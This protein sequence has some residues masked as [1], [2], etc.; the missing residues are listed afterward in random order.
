MASRVAFL[1]PG[2]GSQYVGMGL[3]ASQGHP[4]A[5]ET[6]E[7]AN[8]VLG[9]DL[10]SLCFA[11]PSEVLTDTVNA[12]PAIMATSVAYLRLFQD[13]EGTRS[14]LFVA[15]HS[16][17]EYTALVAAG[18]LSFGDG[19]KLARERGRLMKEAGEQ[20]PGRMAAII[21]MDVEP[22][23]EICRQASGP[24]EMESVQVANYNAPGQIVI[25]G[26]SKAVERAMALAQERGAHRVIPLAVSIASHSPLMRRAADGLR[27]VVKGTKMEPARTPIIANTTAQP[28]TNPDEVRAELVAQLTRS[29]RWIASVEMMVQQG[30]ERFLEIGPRDVLAGLMRRINQDVEMVNVESK[31]ELA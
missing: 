17:G 6:F 31:L 3:K 12:Q 26:E 28:I 23:E 16:M 19:L 11:G 15:G 21:R 29:V 27:Q 14:P 13:M 18:V 10:S 24:T 1:F 25:S 9:F 20:N 4:L 30:V 7:E 8:D 2:Q 5:R 22:L